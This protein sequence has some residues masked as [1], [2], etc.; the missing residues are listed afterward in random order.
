[1]ADVLTAMQCA[2]TCQFGFVGSRVRMHLR[3][4]ADLQNFSQR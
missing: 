1:M 2:F 4:C 3:F